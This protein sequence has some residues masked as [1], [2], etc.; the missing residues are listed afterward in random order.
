MNRTVRQAAP[1]RRRNEFEDLLKI[2]DEDKG[3]ITLPQRLALN[4]LASFEGSAR[5]TA[6]LGVTTRIAR[7]WHRRKTTRHKACQAISLKCTSLQATHPMIPVA[8][9]SE[10]AG[11]HGYQN[12]GVGLLRHPGEETPNSPLV[13]GVCPQRG[14]GNR[15][16]HPALGQYWWRSLGAAL[17]Q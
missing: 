11:G 2:Y 13:R 6:E 9:H 3:A 7:Q 12:H 5:V 8:L 14:A 15:L 17:S 1:L 16:R 4:A 10:V